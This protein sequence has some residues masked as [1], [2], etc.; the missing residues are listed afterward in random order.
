MRLI[1]CNPTFII[2]RFDSNLTLKPVRIKTIMPENITT[3]LRFE[4]VQIDCMIRDCL[5]KK[6]Q[7]GLTETQCT[8][9]AQ[10]A[11]E[12]GCESI[13][14]QAACD[15]V[16]ETPDDDKGYSFISYWVYKQQEQRQLLQEDEAAW[17]DLMW[18]GFSLFPA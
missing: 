3:R 15:K 10:H 5:R 4:V 12:C 17:H 13:S 16:C 7:I 2:L 9:E 14:V 1:F 18:L 8:C 6:R 11:A